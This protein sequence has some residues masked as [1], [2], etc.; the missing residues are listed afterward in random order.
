[1]KSAC[2]FTLIELMTTLTVAAILLLVGVP[3]FQEFSKRNS[4]STLVNQF[5]AD[6][7]FTRSEAIKRSGRVTMCRS[8]NS[9]SC[10]TTTGIGWEKGWI[11]FSDQNGT[12]GSV[13][14]GDTIVRTNGVASGNITIRGNSFVKDRISF[15]SSGIVEPN[16]GTLII[17]DDRVRTYSTDKYKARVII[18]SKV[19]RIRTSKGSESGLSVTSCT[20]S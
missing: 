11:I 18:I 13:D 8:S 9:T 15:T 17:C 14:T 4:L 1:M 2:G 19:G 10:D 6:L 20:P 12:A 7:N 5:V 3:S 16:N